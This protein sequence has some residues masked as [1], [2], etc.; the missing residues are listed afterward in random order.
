[1][2]DTPEQGIVDGLTGVGDSPCSLLTNFFSTKSA[3]C[4][5]RSRIEKRLCPMF[6]CW[7]CPG[8]DCMIWSK[9][10]DYKSGQKSNS[11]L[12]AHVLV[13]V[14]LDICVLSGRGNVG[15]IEGSACDEGDEE[16]E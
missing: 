11:Y 9:Q 2:E 6:R 15:S 1:M 13:E 10:D 16:S 8:T 12:L 4:V 14:V 7:F 5:G 3:Q